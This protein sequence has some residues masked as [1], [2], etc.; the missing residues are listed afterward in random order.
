MLK[1]RKN[2]GGTWETCTLTVEK[3]KA[4]QAKVI[5]NGVAKYHEIK[6]F[7]EEKQVKI[8]EEAIAAILSKVVPSYESLANDYI[9]LAI[10]EQ[11][12]NPPA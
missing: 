11:K 9:E 8:S 6:K 2:I 5:A 3:A 7:A 1:Y 4:I 12:N 10:E